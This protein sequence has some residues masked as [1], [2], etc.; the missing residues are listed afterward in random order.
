MLFDGC[1]TSVVNTSEIFSGCSDKNMLEN[2]KHSFYGVGV[3]GI[4]YRYSFTI[5]E[6]MKQIK[7]KI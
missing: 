2:A 4:P 3:L 6:V 5:A 7:K 1:Y